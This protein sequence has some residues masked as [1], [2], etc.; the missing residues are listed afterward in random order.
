[1]DDYPM[2]IHLL[3]YPT[4]FEFNLISFDS[5]QPAYSFCNSKQYTDL[6]GVPLEYLPA[7]SQLKCEEKGVETQKSNLKSI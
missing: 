7:D 4:S 1:M 5:V 6:L 2:T 3:V